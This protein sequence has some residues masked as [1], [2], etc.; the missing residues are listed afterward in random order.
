MQLAAGDVDFSPEEVE[1]IAALFDI[2]QPFC[3]ADFDEKGNINQ[4]TYLVSAGGADYLLQRINHTVFTRP[5]NVMSAML[6]CIA[7]QQTTLASDSSLAESGWKPIRLVPV[8]TGDPYLEYEEH[9]GATVWRM[10]ERIPSCRTYKSLSEVSER[11]RQLALAEEAGRGLA[12]YGRLTWGMSTEGL[13]NP[14]PGYRHTRTYFDQF[15]SV[16]SGS[17]TQSEAER[18]LPRDPVVRQSTAYHFRVHLPEDEY[19]RRMSEP[20]V[21]HFVSMAQRQEPLAM[22]LTCAMDD[23]SI[24]TVAVHGD[25]KLENFLFSRESGRVRSLVD[26]DTIMPHTWLSDWGDMVRSLANVA[27]EKE[28]DLDKVQVDLE[29]IDALA[30]GF[31]GAAGDLPQAELELMPIAVEVL[32]LELGVRFLMDYL[33]GDSYFVLGP[34]DRRDLNK[35]R[36]MVQ[37]TLFERLQENRPAIISSLRQS[38]SSAR[39]RAGTEA[40][41]RSD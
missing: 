30:R 15:L 27:G 14:L 26:L 38:A 39:V 23:G 2:P 4:H 3:V 33:R 40:A 19:L 21:L 6:A 7:A 20:D 41:F 10:M 32:A 31:L 36:G 28:P 11:S 25:T 37:L 8:R 22:S 34:Q 17:R 29:I 16:L 9:R 1:Q 18:F 5:H 35:V 12:L 24:R 13:E